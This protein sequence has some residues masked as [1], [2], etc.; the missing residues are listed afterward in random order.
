MPTI[1]PVDRCK[2]QPWAYINDNGLPVLEVTTM[3]FMHVV[4][5]ARTIILRAMAG[6]T[7][8]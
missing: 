4:T 5:P 6:I 7:G 8:R 2:W 1:R 3:L